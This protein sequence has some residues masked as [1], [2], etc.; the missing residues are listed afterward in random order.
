MFDVLDLL[1]NNML[2]AYYA[3]RYKGQTLQGINSLR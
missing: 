3:S 2:K 1:A